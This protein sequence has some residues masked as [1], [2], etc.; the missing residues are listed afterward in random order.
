MDPTTDIRLQA[1]LAEQPYPLLFAT[2]SGAHLYG[3]ASPDS[4]YDVRGVHVL[5][6]SELVGLK[7]GRETVEQTSVREG[8]EIDLVTHEVRKFFLLMLKKNGYVLEQIF[9]PLVLR[10][11]PEHAELK[12]RARTCVTRYHCYHYLGF[13]ETQWKLIQKDSPPRVKPLLYLFRVLLTGIHL[14][15]TGE[16]EA[17]LVTL[18][19]TFRLPYLDDLIARKRSGA[20]RGT[21][22]DANRD[23]YSAEYE[24]LRQELHDAAEASALPEAVTCKPALDDL[25]LR[26]R[27]VK[28]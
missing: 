12:E 9:S 10:T 28:H 1:A 22:E 14:M 3:F 11:G 15:R 25:L 27:G 19:E 13:A 6:L 20:E 21:L 24:R 2:L 8:L 23:F 16:I 5:P 26:I 18:N 4:D 7:V 17:N